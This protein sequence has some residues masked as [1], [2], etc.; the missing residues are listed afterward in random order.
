[1]LVYKAGQFGQIC[2]INM[3]PCFHHV[4]KKVTFHP[5]FFLFLFM[6]NFNCDFFSHNYYFFSCNCEFLQFWEQTS[7]DYIF[8]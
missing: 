6:D 4:I 8:I 7:T 5:N 1:M 3:E 2:V